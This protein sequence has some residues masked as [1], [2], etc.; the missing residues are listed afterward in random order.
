MP[1]QLSYGDIS[2]DKEMNASLDSI[3]NLVEL[4]ASVLFANTPTYLYTRFRRDSSVRELAR[5]HGT[6]T[7]LSDL[8]E[9]LKHPLKTVDELVKAYALCIG[10]AFKPYGELS[11]LKEL[12]SNDIEWFEAIKTLVLEDAPKAQHITVRQPVNVTFN[13]YSAS[14][15]LLLDSNCVRKA[16]Q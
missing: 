12:S 15:K 4:R 10:L 9:T 1:L 2:P 11:K 6:K 5:R 7:L 16:A 8:E 3:L 13:E 14:Q